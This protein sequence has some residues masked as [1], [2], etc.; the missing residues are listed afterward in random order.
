MTDSH[1]DIIKASA[2]S[3]KT[4]TLARTYIA[5]LIG[6][7]TGEYFTATINGKEQTLEYY[8]LRKS[9][10][11]HKHILAITFTNKATAEMKDRIIKQLYKL[12]NNDSAYRQEFELMFRG[13]DYEKDVVTAGT[14]VLSEI[15]FD[16]GSFHVKTIDSFFQSILR[17][18][19]R[20][21]DRDYS[22]DL[23]LDED[24]AT[25]V[26]VHDFMKDLGGGNSRQ[27]AI[28]EWVK[29]YIRK[30]IQ[31]NKSWNF[32]G[33][34][35]YLLKFAKNIYKEYFRVHHADILEY[36][37]DIGSGKALSRV[38]QFNQMLIRH[39]KRC[40]KKFEDLHEEIKNFFAR[41]GYTTKEVNGNN[42]IGKL[43]KGSIEVIGESALKTI[44]DEQ[45]DIDELLNTKYIKKAYRDGVTAEQ[46]EEFK[47]LLSDLVSSYFRIAFYNGVSDNIWNMGLLGKIDE[48]LEQ[49]RKDTNSI[50]IADTNELIGKILDSGASFI[51]EHAGTMYY[52][53]MIDEFQDTSRKQYENFKP[54]LNEAIARGNN[55]LIIGD[56]KQSIYRFRNSDPAMLRDEVE[57]DFRSRIMPLDTNYRSSKSIV[58]F[59]NTFFEK[60]I[61]DYKTGAQHYKSIGKTYNNISQKINFNDLPGYVSINFC[62]ESDSMEDTRARICKY[63]PGYINSLRLRGFKMNEIAILVN[64]NNEGNEVVEAILEYNNSLEGG[65]SNERHIDVISGE[66][67]L[68]E[69]SSSVRMIISALQFLES[70]QYVLPPEEADAEEEV[71]EESRRFL[72]FLKKRVREQRRYKLLHDFQQAMQD[73][74]KM[75]DAGNALKECFKKDHENDRLDPKERLNVYNDVSQNL[76]PDSRYQLTNLE[77]I[78]DL[79]IKNYLLPSGHV[80][81]AFLLAFVDVVHQFARQYNGGTVREFLNYWELKKAKLAVS[82]PADANAVKVMTIHKSK[83]LEFKCVIIP[84]AKWDLIKVDSVLWIDKEAWNASQVTIDNGEGKPLN[85]EIIPP[86]I[87]V[88]TSTLKRAKLFED[89]LIEEEERS[90]IDNLN[91]LYVALTRPEEELHVFAILNK[92]EYLDSAPETSICDIKTVAQLLAKFVAPDAQEENDFFSYRN[93][94]LDKL[95]ILPGEDIEALDSQAMADD[96]LPVYSCTAGEPRLVA[97][98]SKSNDA[99]KDEAVL[100]PFDY[101]VRPPKI[102]VHVSTHNAAGSIKS[103]G[104]RVHEIMSKVINTGSF[105]TALL[106]ASSQNLLINTPYWTRERFERLFRSIEENPMLRDW[107]DENNMVF[108][109]RKLSIKPTAENKD[110]EQA[111]A[112]DDKQPAKSPEFRHLRP[113]RM[114]IRPNGQVIIIDYKSGCSPQKATKAMYKA[115]VAEYMIT[116]KSMGYTDIKG[117][118]WYLRSGEIVEAQESDFIKPDDKSSKKANS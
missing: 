71:T 14:R 42:S 2:G 74:E 75:A 64:A 4:Y 17:S 82:S 95:A 6:F 104:L 52:N 3:G 72:N 67:L 45:L 114:V 34:S 51:Y 76:M 57:N 85:P 32:F 111:E 66:S 106:Y 90:L 115:Q 36:L 9:G 110:T 58:E 87:P 33:N 62:R 91:K 84:F 18:F 8:N 56:E 59:N 31:N 94:S 113:D 43:L 44:R 40:E 23:E 25:G 11:Y 118:V 79:I 98:E 50:L 99:K 38:A 116:L 65:M 117:Y 7:P 29:E 89:I 88:K 108:N 97:K 20:E 28:N 53:Y 41:H 49:Y 60:I 77:N 109:E 61:D 55:N 102:G 24:Y 10:E 100:P 83:G 35:D 19:A 12:S 15:L 48:K 105:R 46:N 103:E 93:T 27:A 30:N 21:L 69:N 37:S 16:Y 78:V 5:N 13:C 112:Q 73:P 70:T 81:N 96:A 68:L 1:I 92:L 47:Q 80:E 63:L 86:I 22:Y 54:L 101:V 107:F 26:A 39:R